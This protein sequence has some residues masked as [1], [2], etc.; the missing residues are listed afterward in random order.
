MGPENE[1][2]NANRIPSHQNMSLRYTTKSITQSPS[3]T[4]CEIMKQEDQTNGMS[5]LARHLIHENDTNRRE[6]WYSEYVPSL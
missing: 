2:D 1:T 6:T 3:A 4:D 5:V